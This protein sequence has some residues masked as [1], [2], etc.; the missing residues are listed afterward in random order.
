MKIGRYV[1]RALTLLCAAL[2]LGSGAV[3]AEPWD[4]RMLDGITPV[5]STLTYDL[6]TFTAGSLPGVLNLDFYALMRNLSATEDMYVGGYYEGFSGVA[7]SL[8]GTA[9]WTSQGGSE[10]GNMVSAGSSLTAW[11]GTFNAAGYLASL[12]TDGTQYEALIDFTYVAVDANLDPFD[13]NY[14]DGITPGPP[15]LRIYGRVNPSGPPGPGPDPIPEASTLTLLGSLG[16]WAAP[17]GLWR[18]RKL[19]KPEQA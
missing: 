14:P 13:S 5:P 1:L 18:Y 6:G 3:Q 10:L 17:L 11:L 2:A 19:R 12:P 9:W 4:L 15:S 7:P 16:A 8:D